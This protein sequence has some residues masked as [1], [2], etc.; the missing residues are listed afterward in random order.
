MSLLYLTGLE[1]YR[2]VGPNLPTTPFGTWLR[3]F[4]VPTQLRVFQNE[5]R[6]QI[7]AP[8]SASDDDMNTLRSAWVE[9]LP[10]EYNLSLA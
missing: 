2:T 9:L 3:P 6:W 4:A 8:I 7:E 5:S 1:R 10:S